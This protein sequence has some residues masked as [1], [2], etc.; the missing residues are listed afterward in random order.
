M[1]ERAE[2]AVAVEAEVG[3][4]GPRG[5]AVVENGSS[6]IRPVPNFPRR[7]SATPRDDRRRAQRR[8]S[9]RGSVLRGRAGPELGCQTVSCVSLRRS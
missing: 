7:G 6:S 9:C 1:S 4:A 2:L 3:A 5:D 8:R